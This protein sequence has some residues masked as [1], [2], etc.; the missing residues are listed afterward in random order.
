MRKLFWLLSTFVLMTSGCATAP[1][2]I[3]ASDLFLDAKFAAP[4]APVAT[5]KL[6]TLNADMRRYLEN[7]IAQQSRMKG[8]IHGLID[9][10]Y[11][12]GQLKLEY[13]TSQT[14]NAQEAFN[15]RSG[16]CLSLVIMTAAF[17]R[18]M[19]LP[20]RFHSVFTDETWSR[21]GNVLFSAGH[22]NITLGQ[23]N[24]HTRL[25]AGESAPLTIDFF[26]TPAGRMQ[27]SWEIGEETIVAMY[28]NNRAA[29]A[30]A[31]E[32]LDDAYWWAREA[33]LRDPKFFAAY[34]T[35]GVIY[36][37]YGQHV[38]A[39]RALRHVLAIE[40][41]NL[42]AMSN[43]AIV[44]DGLGRNAEATQL[45]RE[46]ERLRPFAPFHFF[47]LGMAAM[48]EKQF[49]VARD[50]FLKEVN[51]AAYNPEFHFW[52]GAAYVGLGEIS[53]AQHHLAIAL[54]NSS[55][56]REQAIYAAKLDWVKR[57]S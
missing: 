12:P 45:A 40:P 19:G 2:P 1:P 9:A 56:K 6:F 41:G 49:V 44:L 47:D 23:L 4:S 20:V 35:L 8:R 17:A 21:S 32:E 39:E 30:L 50:Y 52:L 13:D 5:D 24:S 53:K 48:K 22:V 27:H 29:E 10:L 42:S 34:N 33:V 43:L 57:R 37:R 15:A 46:V 28:L 26:A 31:R 38:A 25:N 54:E 7:E 16:N 36:R 55:T 51:R 3:N 11:T 14:R 18:E